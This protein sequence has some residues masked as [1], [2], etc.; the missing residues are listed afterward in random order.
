[1]A[2]ILRN[3]DIVDH[4]INELGITLE[5]GVDYEYDEGDIHCPELENLIRDGVVVFVD[6][7]GTEY[8]PEKTLS[9][10]NAVTKPIYD[11][12]YLKEEIDQKF[13]DL[14]GSA[15]SALDT[16]NELAEA[17]GNDPNFATTITNEL[18]N[19]ADKNHVH[20]YAPEL[21]NHD[22]IYNT[23]Q[24]IQTLLA[25]KSNIGHNHD[26]D[27]SQINHNHNRVYSQINHN[28]D[29]VYVKPEDL[30][31]FG[32]NYKFAV[33]RTVTT[34]T[35]LSVEKLVLD[36]DV[37]SDGFYRIG[38]SYNWNHDSTGYD[39]LA[40]IKIDNMII[41]EHRQEPKDSAGRFG[42][43][44]TDQKIPVGGFDV[45]KLTKG[46]KRIILSFG[47]SKNRYRSSIWNIALEF[48]RV[49]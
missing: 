34:T 24:Q 4:E 20:P 35:E 43:T 3:K 44:G 15:S 2:Y 31:V 1:M 16:L 11:A 26:S 46:K 21:H 6:V 37:M 12:V 40:K 47:S 39:F 28:H 27:Y 33:D 22:D 9:I 8:T 38:W 32:Q 10:Y 30:P 19:K 42:N 18:A 7:D 14:V 13:A 48:W 29:D 49:Q 17:L 5:V 41:M 36:V 23:K 25:L 45:V